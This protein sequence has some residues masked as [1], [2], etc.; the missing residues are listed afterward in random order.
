MSVYVDVC[1][2]IPVILVTLVRGMQANIENYPQ[3]KANIQKQTSK[4]FECS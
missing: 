1:K 2:S 3:L 4:G